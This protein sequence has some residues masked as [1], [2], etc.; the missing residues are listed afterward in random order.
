MVG[1][2]GI[3]SGVT[4]FLGE[5]AVACHL[6]SSS[7]AELPELC[8]AELLLGLICVENSI[9]GG[10]GGVWPLNSTYSAGKLFF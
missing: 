4:G 10:G 6:R 9:F 7:R 2:S 1:V 5:E 8:Y 3:C